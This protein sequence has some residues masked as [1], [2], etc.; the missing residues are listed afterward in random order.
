MTKVCQQIFTNYTEPK[1]IEIC[2][3]WFR[4][5]VAHCHWQ[6]YYSSHH[7]WFIQSI[8]EFGKKMFGTSN[9]FE[10]AT[11]N[12]T[13]NPKRLHPS[14]CNE[15][16]ASVTN[17]YIDMMPRYSNCLHENYF[18]LPLIL[19]IFCLMFIIIF[20]FWF[21]AWSKIR[22][23]HRNCVIKQ[24]VKISADGGGDANKLSLKRHLYEVKRF[25]VP[26]NCFYDIHNG[27][28][29]ATYE[30]TTK[31]ELCSVFA[32]LIKKSPLNTINNGSIQSDRQ[33]RIIFDFIYCNSDEDDENSIE[34]KTI[35]TISREKTYIVENNRHHSKLNSVNNVE[36]LSSDSSTTSTINLKEIRCSKS[37]RP[38]TIAGNNNKNSKRVC[39]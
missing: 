14:E 19:I 15:L 23:K 2:Q 9:A 26:K 28:S 32:K 6:F 12:L 21:F 38:I 37:K 27:P 31:S 22:Q 29:L 11:M 8:F 5:A 17:E 35:K 34:C 4:Y 39:R 18:I 16:Y 1:D 24:N 13:K 30:V 20:I 33:Y 10:I 7:F 3:T 36:S 25:K